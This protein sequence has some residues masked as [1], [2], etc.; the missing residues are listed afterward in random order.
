M[1]QAQNRVLPFDFVQK[2]WNPQEILAKNSDPP[3]P[4]IQL[5][6]MTNHI[7]M[8]LAHHLKIICNLK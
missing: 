5:A 8:S 4:D 7:I 2:A 1:Q 3:L 6:M